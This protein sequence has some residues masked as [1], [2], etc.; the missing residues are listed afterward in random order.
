[1]VSDPNRVLIERLG[2]K[3]VEKNSTVRS[4]FVFEKGTGKLLDAQIGIKPNERCVGLFHSLR[5]PTPYLRANCSHEAALAF[6][7]GLAESR[8]VSL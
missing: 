6:L 5:I 1:M 3:N 4:H 2:A 8:E 7:R